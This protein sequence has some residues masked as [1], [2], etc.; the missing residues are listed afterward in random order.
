MTVG[1]WGLQS[2]GLG[3]LIYHLGRAQAGEASQ[4]EEEDGGVIKLA[5]T[6]YPVGNGVERKHYIDQRKDGKG[7]GDPRDAPVLP[8][9]LI[10]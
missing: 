6:G 5:Q 1:R 9:T 8:Q 7:L 2:H 10:E 3:V 4:G